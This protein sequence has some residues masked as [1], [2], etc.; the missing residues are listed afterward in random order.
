[1]DEIRTK[2]DGEIDACLNNLKAMS[3]DDDKYEDVI[4]NLGALYRLRIEEEKLDIDRE[5]K[6][7]RLE[8]EK[9]MKQEQIDAEAINHRDE[10][11]LKNQQIKVSKREIWINLGIAGATIIIPL[12]VELV[13]YIAGMKFEET[14]TITSRF[15]QMMLN[16]KL[17]KHKK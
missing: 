13:M 5:D 3:P 11:E 6:E 14:G 10:I 12:G 1:M 15:F 8:M 4:N 17:F 7:A 2:L 16:S 9:Q